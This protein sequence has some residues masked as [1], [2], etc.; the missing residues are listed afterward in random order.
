VL[1]EGEWT[2]DPSQVTCG[3]CERTLIHQK[4]LS[5][6]V[7][8]EHMTDSAKRKQDLA[9]LARKARAAWPD[10]DPVRKHITGK[11]V[12]RPHYWIEVCGVKFHGMGEGVR[13]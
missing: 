7:L 2:N 3:N 10:L 8:V 9:S 12:R 6:Y 5:E 1:R 4:A 11:P 13:R